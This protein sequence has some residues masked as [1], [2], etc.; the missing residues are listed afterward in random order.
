[1]NSLR[2][3]LLTT[4]SEDKDVVNTT[5]GKRLLYSASEFECPKGYRQING[6]EID[7]SRP[8][9]KAAQGILQDLDVGSEF[10]EK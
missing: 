4:Q 5:R 7:T 1:M 10:G 9:K 2:G 3:E 6:Q 8:E